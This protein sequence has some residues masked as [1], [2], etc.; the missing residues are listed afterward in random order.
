MPRVYNYVGQGIRKVLYPVWEFKDRQW[1][2]LDPNSR[3]LDFN[4]FNCLQKKLLKKVTT[5]QSRY[6]LYVTIFIIGFLHELFEYTHVFYSHFK[7][8]VEQSY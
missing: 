6:M 7:L 5:V 1:N 4:D 8:N 3:S 2:A